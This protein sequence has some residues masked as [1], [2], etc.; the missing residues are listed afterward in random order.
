M[1]SLRGS[2]FLG[3]EM[4]LINYSSL[5]RSLEDVMLSISIGGM[6]SAVAVELIRGGRGNLYGGSDA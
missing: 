6:G 5:R 2:L 1:E 4:K 3:V